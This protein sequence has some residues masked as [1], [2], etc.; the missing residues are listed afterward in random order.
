M[1]RK[2]SI[3]FLLVI[4][5]LF[6]V[7]PSCGQSGPQI[8][9][10]DDNFRTFYQIFVGSF[11]D[12]SND[13]IGDIRGIIDR[14]NY[15]NDGDVNSETSLGVQGIWLSPIFSSPTYHKYDA[16]DYY[17][18][19]W[20]FGTEEDL[21]ELVELCHS[22]NVKIILDLAINHTS[23]YHPWFQAFK[24]ARMHG[25]TENKYYDYYSCVKAAEKVG[26]VSY[27]KI[28]GVDCWYECN[29]SGSMP[30]LN[31]DNPEVRE[32]A[33]AI[34]RHYLTLGVDGFR[35]DAVKYIYYGDTKRSADFW[36][37]YMSELRAEYPD[38][39]CVGECWSGDTEIL[40]YYGAM[41]CFAFAMSQ[42]EGVAA[43]A[44][45]GTSISSFTGYVESMQ[46]R[47]LE[48]NPDG[49][50]MPFL[51]NHDMDRIAGAF[52]TENHMRMAAN[53]YLLCPG[54]PV[55]YYGEELGMRGSRGGENTD[56]NR[57]L[58]ML[59]G[60]GDL[61]RDPVGSTYPANKQIQTTVADQQAD[62]TSMYRYYCRLL[63][64]RHRYPAIARGQ[65]TAI[66]CGHKNLGG[67]V[68]EYGDQTFVLIHNTSMESQS[69]DLASCGD[70]DGYAVARICE[71]IG[72]GNATLDGTVL[73]IDA[74]T[75]VLL[76]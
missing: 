21:K 41:N 58:A 27:Q 33:L 32:E 42:A 62:E 74:Q 49:M 47:I 48:K 26:G 73:T 4:V 50:L 75:T 30:E 46:T 66:G 18:I 45:K 5:M 37:W 68:I 67:F 16:T 24:E 53:L 20:R 76:K 34:A 57:R 14:M 22:R 38:I 2:Q 69:V 43:K 61:I 10:V 65:Y 12:A 23:E 52:V 36:G 29:F 19:D 56:A 31:F 15:L 8:D 63:N 13:G 44:A 7:L 55:I 64:I 28:A 11:S 39:Y 71:A 54:S 25:D 9:P 3:L 51:S 72:V 59:W 40:S 35:F 17:T 60:D 6:S 70:L 1:I